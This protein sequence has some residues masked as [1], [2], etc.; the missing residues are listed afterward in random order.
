VTERFVVLR[1]NAG[2]YGLHPAG[3]PAPDGWYPTMFT[4]PE[5]ECVRNVDERWAA[6]HPADPER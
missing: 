3:E 4:G 2:Q 6:E 1:N 5:A